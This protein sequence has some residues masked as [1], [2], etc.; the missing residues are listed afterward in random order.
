MALAQQREVVRLGVAVFDPVQD[1]VRVEAGLVGAA[2]K[3]TGLV[4]RFERSSQRMRDPLGAS[5]DRERLAVVFDEAHETRVTDHPP[6]RLRCDRARP[7]DLAAGSGSVASER[8]GVDVDDDLIGVG[9]RRGLVLG[10]PG[11]GHGHERVGPELF[12][13]VPRE[14]ALVRDRGSLITGARAKEAIARPKQRSSKK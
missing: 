5:S 9:P 12:G 10:E 2:G 13:A 8:V 4:A 14:S 6:G 11:L 7:G 3:A 1:V